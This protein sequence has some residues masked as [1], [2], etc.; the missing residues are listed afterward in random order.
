MPHLRQTADTGT[1]VLGDNLV[2]ETHSQYWDASRIV[3]KGALAHPV[4][5]RVGDAPWAGRQDKMCRVVLNNLG[6]R[7][8]VGE[9]TET[10]TFASNVVREVVGKGVEIIYHDDSHEDISHSTVDLIA[11]ASISKTRSGRQTST[12]FTRCGKLSS[13]LRIYSSKIACTCSSLK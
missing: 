12:W 13:F 11:R 1:V 10:L 5:V 4:A 2:P 3:L 6:E 7:N 8:V 9:N